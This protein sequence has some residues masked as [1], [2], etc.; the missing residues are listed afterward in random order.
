LFIRKGFHPYTTDNFLRSNESSLVF[1]K[2]TKIFSQ[3]ILLLLDKLEDIPGA[4]GIN[5]KKKKKKKKLILIINYTNIIFNI[6]K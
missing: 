2:M 4:K 6:N 3:K 5:K 1:D